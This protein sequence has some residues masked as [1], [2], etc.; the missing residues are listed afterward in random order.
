MIEQA[1]P[2]LR[3]VS[4]GEEQWSEGEP[5]VWG[6]Q[7][8]VEGILY[9][10]LYCLLAVGLFGY[11]FFTLNP[12]N[13]ARIPLAAVIYRPSMVWLAVVQSLIFVLLAWVPVARCIGPSAAF[14]RVVVV[15]AVG[16]LAEYIGTETGFPFGSYAYTE[17]MGP[18][19]AG[20]VPVVIPP[21]WF[22]VGLPCYVLA[23][24]YFSPRG[25]PWVA[26]ACRLVGGA[27]L[28]TT[29]DFVLDPAM[30][31]LVPYWTWDE[32]GFFYNSPFANFVGWFVT[33]LLIMSLLEFLFSNQIR[34]R[35]VGQATRQVARLYG[36]NYV[37]PL[38]MCFFSFEWVPCLL[39][40]CALAPL[41]LSLLLERR[42]AQH[43]AL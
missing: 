30:S 20:N 32:P 10:A 16:F 19:L 1:R 38:G 27:W 4:G 42:A 12:E 9:R 7:D 29:W 26:R 34:D 6:L 18:K 33:G 11:V 31:Y 22:A 3:G 15:S 36:L 5:R 25:S 39:V 2:T 13:L 23:V 41:W 35:L 37:M 8:R 24:R 28:L 17:L 14:A 21:S 43:R 40:F